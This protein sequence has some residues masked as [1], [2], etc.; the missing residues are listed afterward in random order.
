[1][2]CEVLDRGRRLALAGT[3]FFEKRADMIAIEWLRHVMMESGRSRLID[4]RGIRVTRDGDAQCLKP[5]PPNFADER[6]ACAVGKR[7]VSDDGVE[8]LLAQRLHT[9]L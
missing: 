1:M 3:A 4:I 2:G 5:S 7:N 6:V 9:G 8:S